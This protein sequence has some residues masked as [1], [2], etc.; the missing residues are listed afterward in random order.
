MVMAALSLS[1]C[2][3]E[4]N[5]EPGGT[6]VEKMAGNWDVTFVGVDDDAMKR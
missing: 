5:V 3:T 1:S 2:D 6:A 4:T